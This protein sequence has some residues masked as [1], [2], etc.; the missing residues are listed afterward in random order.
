M[1]NVKS[2]TVLGYVYKA[3]T[4]CPDCMLG[5]L[6]DEHPGIRGSTVEDIGTAI[7]VDWEDEYSYDSSEFPKVIFADHVEDDVC[8]ECG[9][10]L[11]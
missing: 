2:W 5:I 11:L 7:G 1:N 10:F 6:R 8:A 4:Y 3:D 9:E